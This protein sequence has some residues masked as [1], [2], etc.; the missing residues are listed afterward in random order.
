MGSFIARLLIKSLIARILTKIDLDDLLFFVDEAEAQYDNPFAKRGHVHRAV[1]AAEPE[2][3]SGTV[4]NLAIEL[5][6]YFY[7]KLQ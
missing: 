3:V 5:G 1:K 7:K 4:V 2:G 6:V